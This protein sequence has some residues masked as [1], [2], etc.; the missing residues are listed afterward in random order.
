MIRVSLSP[1]WEVNGH[2]G[3]QLDRHCLPLLLAIERSGRL[4]EAA[5]H[6]DLSYRH[7]WNLLERWRALFGQPLV[8]LQRG[9][10]ARLTPLGLRLVRAEQRLRARLTPQLMSLAAE[11]ETELNQAL[12]GPAPQLRIHASHGFAIALLRER[13]E[14]YP[15]LRW[16]LQFKGGLDAVASLH[17]RNCELAGFH[18]P[19]GG[20]DEI[21]NDY[22]PWLDPDQVVLPFVIRRQGLILPKGNPRRIRSL[23]ELARPGLRFVNR[24]RGSGSRALLDHLLREAR[25]ETMA[26]RGYQHEEFTH[27]A[28]AA[29]VASGMADAGFGVEAAAREFGLDFL[30]L[31][32]EYYSL[33]CWRE[34][35]SNPALRSL[36][37]LL[38]EPG[39]Q[40]RIDAVPGYLC[41]HAGETWSLTD[42]LARWRAV[43]DSATLL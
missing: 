14:Q 15:D 8:E 27:S 10:G 9:R 23:S 31:A 1:Q 24:Q 2:D 33:L 38:A 36:L 17:Q 11:I 20:S 39:F 22:L 16:E 18:L 4:T 41:A 43:A 25:V 13:L 42:A 21:L 7:A 30:P 19:R 6:C 34:T 37:A 5:R 28:V 40:R 3:E 32:E 12:D 26:L 29:F 35:L